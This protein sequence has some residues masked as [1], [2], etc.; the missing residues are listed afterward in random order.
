[1]AVI[2]S[3]VVAL[4][5]TL[6]ATLDAQRVIC[7]CIVIFAFD[8]MKTQIVIYPNNR[9]I[10]NIIKVDTMVCTYRSTNLTKTNIY[11][12]CEYVK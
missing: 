12:F 2:Y 6:L 11:L 9:I 7:L 5:T 1:M 3:T 10:V 8:G 4:T